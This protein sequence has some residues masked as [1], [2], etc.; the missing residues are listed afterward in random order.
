M[1][2]KFSVRVAES[3]DP[4]RPFIYSKD[5]EIVIYAKDNPGVILQTSTFGDTATDYRIDGDDELYITNFRT[6]A[7]ATTYVVEV[8]RY[9]AGGM[10]V[11]SFEFSTVR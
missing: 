1:P 6:L 10:L 3:D 4:S 5:L 7:T 9:K 2:I 8:Y 11:G